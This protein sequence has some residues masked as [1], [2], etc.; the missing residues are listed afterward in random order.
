VRG[1]VESGRFGLLHFRIDADLR[2]ALFGD[3]PAG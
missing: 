1:F 2:S 3:R